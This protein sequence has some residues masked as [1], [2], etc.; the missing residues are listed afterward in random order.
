MKILKV[1]FALLLIYSLQACNKGT[2]WGIH[3]KGNNISETRNNGTF[4]KVEVRCDADVDIISDSTF[5]IDV[6][7]QENILR[8]LDTKIEGTTLIIEF[9]KRVRWHSKIKIIIHLKDLNAIILSGSGNINAQNNLAANDLELNIS[10][11][12]NI[13]VPSVTVQNLNGNISGS[14]NINISGGTI[15][16]AKF[17]VSGSGNINASEELSTTVKAKISGSG[18]ISINVFESLTAGIS[19]SGHIKYKGTPVINSTISGSG[20]LIHI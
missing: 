4:N 12:G 15:T 14:G 18:N 13:S 19:G 9:N 17:S 2:L 10:G 8:V 20:S 16:S 7:A 3:G 11:S 6:S 1:I 5:N